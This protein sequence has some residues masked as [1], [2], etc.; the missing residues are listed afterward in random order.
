MGIDFET[1]NE[2]YEATR[3]YGLLENKSIKK[4][5][6]KT[7]CLSMAIVDMSDEEIMEVIHE[8]QQKYENKTL[9]QS[10]ENIS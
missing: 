9:S 10:A 7:A 3:K 6:F 5:E 4:R 8:F 1:K 2:A